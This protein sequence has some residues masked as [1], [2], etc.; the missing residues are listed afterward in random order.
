MPVTVLRLPIPVAL[1][2]AA[3]GAAFAQEPAAGAPPPADT[4]FFRPQADPSL[5][6]RPSPESQLRFEL[7]LLQQER[8]R[9]Q[10]EQRQLL[11]QSQQLAA[12]QAA[13]QQ[14]AAPPAPEAAAAPPAVAAIPPDP[15]AAVN[16]DL[17]L[18][19]RQ[20]DRNETE[21]EQ[22]RQPK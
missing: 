3:S 22:A 18:A 5:T 11:E 21:N 4:G 17:E 8:A 19:E 6:A 20:M 14:A 2:W 12:Q 16:R 7:Q 10:E 13:L 15:A 9:L 1:L